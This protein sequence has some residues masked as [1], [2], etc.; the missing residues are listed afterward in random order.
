MHVHKTC[1]SSDWPSLSPH[2]SKLLISVQLPQKVLGFH[3]FYSL[4]E[5]KYHFSVCS[6]VSL[7]FISGCA[8]FLFVTAHTDFLLPLLKAS[9]AYYP[10]EH[11]QHVA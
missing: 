2:H 3:Q 4:D 7:Y 5:A 10:S 11:F 6:L 8:R 1:C 9:S